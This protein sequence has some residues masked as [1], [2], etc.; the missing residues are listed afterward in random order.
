MKIQDY[1]LCEDGETNVSFQEPTVRDCFQFSDLNPKLEQKAITDYLNHMMSE[2]QQ[3]D[4]K[5][6]TIFDRQ[7][8]L[9]WIYVLS[10]DDKTV[11]QKYDCGHCGEE[12]SSPLDLTRLFG[13][14]THAER[15]MSEPFELSGLKGSFVPLRG[16]AMEHLEQLKNERDSHPVNSKAYRLCDADL[17]LYRVAHSMELDSDNQKL[18]H[19]KRADERVEV[20]L[21]MNPEPFKALIARLR[22]V[23][24]E[25]RHGLPC[26]IRDGEVLLTAEEHQCPN[27]EGASTRLMLP[28]QVVDYMPSL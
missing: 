16:Y 2:G 19:D 25:M 26:V 4:A 18:S 23:I 12:H 13:N 5:T 17:Y 27:K 15:S 24:S 6:W 21:G 3:Q 28:F 11:L 22:E 8:A 7:T 20:L 9:V 14:L 10:R 1:T